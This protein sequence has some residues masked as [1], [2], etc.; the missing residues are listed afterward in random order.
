MSEYVVTLQVRVRVEC[1]DEGVALDKAIYTVQG[2]L[3]LSCFGGGW[4]AETTGDVEVAGVEAVRE[5]LWLPEGTSLVRGV[6]VQESGDSYVL[7]NK[8]DRWAQVYPNAHNG[9][10]TW[11]VNLRRNG[12]TL[13]DNGGS[14]QGADFSFQGALLRAWG[15]VHHDVLVG[16]FDPD[17]FDQLTTI[18][19]KAGAR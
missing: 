13:G 17:V 10:Q 11:G 6:L 3:P 7:R 9:G 18:A 5:E 16:V 19:V 4:S 8:S 12:G 2:F 15:Y 1:Q 14:F